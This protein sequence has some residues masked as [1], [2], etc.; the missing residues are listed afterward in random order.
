ML[1]SV[2]SAMTTAAFR[3]KAY[4]VASEWGEQIFYKWGI[5]VWC[6][7][8][9]I[10][11]TTE[12]KGH[13]AMN[14]IVQHETITPV[15]ILFKGYTLFTGP[16]KPLFPSQKLPE[17][18]PLGN[19]LILPGLSLLIRASEANE[20][21]IVTQG[22]DGLYGI[23]M[24]VNCLK[25]KMVGGKKK[26]NSW[27]KFCLRR[28][29]LPKFLRLIWKWIILWNYCID[30]LSVVVIQFFPRDFAC[31]ENELFSVPIYQ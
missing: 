9:M 16:L 3:G 19:T 10:A 14:I 17:G 12:F 25:L 11:W 30:L 26:Q 24:N 23:L 5:S 28:F 6:S 13:C 31:G 1:L 18:K 4:G 27:V 20:Q 15:T 21:N 22:V 29:F 8:N 2:F 7:V